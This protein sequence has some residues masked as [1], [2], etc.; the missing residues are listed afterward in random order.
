MTLNESD[1]RYIN[2]FRCGQFERTDKASV[3]ML[4]LWGKMDVQHDTVAVCQTCRRRINAFLYG[5]SIY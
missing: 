3:I 2:C 4:A 1:P 5:N